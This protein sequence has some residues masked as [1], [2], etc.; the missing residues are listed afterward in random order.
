METTWLN[1]IG[2]VLGIGASP[3][4][5]A[6]SVYGAFRAWDSIANPL[7]RTKLAAFLLAGGF[8]GEGA[9]SAKVVLT[10]FEGIFG[11]G[12]LSLKC[13]RRS[14]IVTGIV[15]IVLALMFHHAGLKVGIEI[16][17]YHGEYGALVAAKRISIVL[18][19]GFLMSLL[20]DFFSLWKGRLILRIM[21]NKPLSIQVALIICDILISVLVSCACFLLAYIVLMILG[22]AQY[23]DP[24]QAQ[25]H[26][27][28]W[29]ALCDLRVIGV[30]RFDNLFDPRTYYHGQILFD[31]TLFTSV[32]AVLVGVSATFLRL[33]VSLNFLTKV[34]QLL[35]DVNKKPFE[36]LGLMAAALTFVLCIVTSI[37]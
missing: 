2:T 9:D 37:L 27:L 7:L 21:Q 23:F 6:A 31:S 17:S 15:L 14:A 1:G 28:K 8:R 18:G 11:P 29:V 10:L 32:W 22:Y 19:L 4:V 35:F 30:H 33:L 25:L 16:F 20:P 13:L 3:V 36:S 5:A 24:V 26:F 34:T 12:Q